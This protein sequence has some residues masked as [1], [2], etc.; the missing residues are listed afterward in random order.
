MAPGR[1]VLHRWQ[2]RSPGGLSVP[3][4]AFGHTFSLSSGSALVA[5]TDWAGEN[6]QSAQ[7]VVSSG[8]P[9]PQTGQ[10]VVGSGAVKTWEH[11][12]L[13]DLPSRASGSFSCCPHAGQG[14]TWDMLPS[15]R[16]GRN[17]QASYFPFSIVSGTS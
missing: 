11:L 12:H 4:A 7:A 13:T 6:P 2:R 9:A 1:G 14:T 8:S 5:A 15:W 3:Q 16:A 17:G 10:V